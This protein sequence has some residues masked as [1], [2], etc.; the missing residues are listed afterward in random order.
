MKRGYG[1]RRWRE[2]RRQERHT[3]CVSHMTSVPEQESEREREREAEER[4]ERVQ[5]RGIRETTRRGGRRVVAAQPHAEERQETWSRQEA[6]EGGGEERQRWKEEE[7]KEGPVPL[8]RV[9][10]ALDA[11]SQLR[12]CQTSFIKSGKSSLKRESVLEDWK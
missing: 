9:S 2:K 11:N 7:E 5:P 12:F 10:S 6:V 3:G 8:W 1:W 4:R